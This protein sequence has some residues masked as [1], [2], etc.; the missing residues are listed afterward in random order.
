MR[1]FIIEQLYFKFGQ[2]AIRSIIV[3]MN[4]FIAFNKLLA[5]HSLKKVN[6]ILSRGL[7]YLSQYCP[8]STKQ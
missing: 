8:L 1:I 7:S 3:K 4:S 5:C 6:H 2:H